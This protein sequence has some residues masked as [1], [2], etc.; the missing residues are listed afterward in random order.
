MTRFIAAR[1]LRI[2]YIIGLL[3]IALLVTAS[4]VT[5][6]RIVSEQG[7][8]ARIIN[9]AGHQS[10]LSNRIA[11][12]AGLMATTEDPTDFNMARAQVGRTVHKMER[13][14]KVLREGDPDQGVPRVE[15]DTLR[16]IYDD[17]MVGLDT[18]LQRYLERARA[19]YDKPMDELST[20][21]IA[22]IFLTTYGPHVLEPMFDA[23]VDE[24]ER[25]SSESIDRIQGLELAIWLSALATLLLEAFLIFRPLERRIT[26]TM[27]QLQDER[28]FLQ[29]VIDGVGDPILV[30]DMN[31]EVLRVNTAARDLSAVRGEGV[32][33]LLACRA[34]RGA[35]AGS[36]DCKDNQCA[37]QRVLGNGETQRLLQN[38][39]V[40][41]GGQSTVEI[42]LS[43]LSDDNGKVVGVIETHRDITEHLQLL[44]KLR[45]S[46]LS[47][48]H[49][50]QHDPLTGLPNRILF[51]DRLGQA[52][53]EAHRQ[54]STLGVLFIDLDEFKLVN[55]SYDH[56]FGDEVLKAVA[57]RIGRVMREDDTLARMG[58]D[59]FT[60]ILRGLS[61]VDAA[62]VVAQK[63]LA[64]FTQPFVVQQQTIFL[65]ASIGI[66]VYPRHG[67]QAEDLVRKADTAMYR[68]KEEGKN[69]FRYYSKGMT[70]KA[71]QRITL[72]TQIRRAL[73]NQEFELHY[74]PQ[75]KFSTGRV[76]GLEAL[77]RWRTPDGDLVPPGHFIPTAEECGLIVELGEWIMEESCRQMKQWLDDGVVASSVLICVNISAK[78]FDK[79]G[80]VKLVDRVLMSSGLSPANLELEITE[81]TMMRAP[82]VTRRVLR[83]LRDLGVEISI[84]DFGTGYSSLS[85]LKL[86]PLTKLKIDKSFVAD[87]PDDANAS[88]IARAIIRLGNSLSLD[89]L[90]EGVET[91]EQLAFLRREGC[92]TGQG[93]LFAKP[94]P[95]DELVAHLAKTADH[96]RP[97]ALL[98]AP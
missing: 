84:D 33:Q 17:P 72:E 7:D 41:D 28:G 93:Y 35:E 39:D 12:F 87:T 68:A 97:L 91:V 24:Y 96:T 42:S 22:Y 61:H 19:V 1:S 77:V 65:G 60:V 57:E 73:K 31:Y 85:H 51:N 11:Y 70:L 49:L 30:T 15:N 10:G 46:E 53:H 55:D 6:Q 63:V 43:P 13:V 78:Q 94:L 69:T 58:G 40:P 71:M 89:T 74:Q 52:L 66:S 20:D 56:G 4:Y 50:A 26:R 67:N 27:D 90:A 92:D 81:S 3:M 75:I 83:E 48:A 18:A 8:F 34:A 37:R 29:H 45:A 98:T 21:S 5:M 59:E 79:E 64:L 25:I 88:A 14:H 47:F 80:L 9:L 62:G 38:Y 23:V 2:R 95:A 44:D 82:A 54:S 36:C 32:E 16:L 86:L 76:S